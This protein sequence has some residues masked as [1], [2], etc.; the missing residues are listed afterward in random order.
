MPVKGLAFQTKIPF[1]IT[2]LIEA[3]LNFSNLKAGSTVFVQADINSIIKQ[4]ILP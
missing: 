2:G 3:L 4:M 1:C